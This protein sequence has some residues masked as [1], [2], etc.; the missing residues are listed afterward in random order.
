MMMKSR[1]SNACCFL[2]FSTLGSIGCSQ[3]PEGKD[4]DAN[5]DSGSETEGSNTNGSSSDGSDG[6]SSSDGSNGGSSNGGS[7][8]G[9]SSSDGGD[10]GGSSNGGSSAGGSGN[11]GSTTDAGT[12]AE[13]PDPIE[14][15]NP[16]ETCGL[17][18]AA[19]CET[20]ESVHPGGRGG[21]MDETRLSFARWNRTASEWWTRQPASSYHDRLPP[22][23]TFCGEEFQNI[24][25]PNDV[26]VCDGVGVDGK[27]SGQLQEVF[28]DQHDFAYQGMRIRQLFDFTD[29]T[30]TIV[31]DVDAK[32]NPYN[33]GHGWWIEMWITEDPAPLP[34]HEAP[35]GVFAFPRKGIGIQFTRQG[36]E[37][38]IPEDGS[39]WLNTPARILS[40]NNHKVLHD[41]QH[42]AFAEIGDDINFRSYDAKMNHIEIKISQSRMEIWVSDVDDPLNTRF[43]AAVT[44]IDLDFSKGYVH[45][46]HAHYNAGKDGLPGC[47]DGVPNTCPSSSQTYRWDNLGFDGPVYPMPR[48][49]DFADNDKLI[50]E[51]EDIHL[52]GFRFTDSEN[53]HTMSVEDVDLTD[54]IS[55][56]LNFNIF[57]DWGRPLEWSFNGGPTHT[58]EVPENQESYGT[59][60]LRSFSVEVPVEELKAGKN[61][62][63]V[64][65]PAPYTVSEAIG[66]LDLTLNVSK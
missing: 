18:N 1:I 13:L 3:S 55:A 47:G 37:L 62:L 16:D 38:E 22:V 4:D 32:Q 19:F 66:N 23:A 10:T 58:F 12:T 52:L 21:E 24:L 20:F 31:F 49:Y 9:G 41:M 46:E 30:G 7:S 61:T 40:V 42:F 65:M 15:A 51:A 27:L 28:D 17:E 44:D 64:H 54:A 29:R 36:H 34:Y 57:T 11:G 63:Q 60:G 50:N 5:A 48:A 43:R 45:F 8:N 25:P 39:Y 59:F 26:R 33:Q 53:T 56:T 2:L 6:G 35:G 14:N